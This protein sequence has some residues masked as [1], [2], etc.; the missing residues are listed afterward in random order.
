VHLPDLAGPCFVS[1]PD[2]EECGGGGSDGNVTK[3]VYK[4]GTAD[5]LLATLEDTATQIDKALGMSRSPDTEPEDVARLI[6]GSRRPR[7]RR[8]LACRLHAL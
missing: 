3:Q 1:N 5:H 2:P 7:H 6:G 8:L 4:V